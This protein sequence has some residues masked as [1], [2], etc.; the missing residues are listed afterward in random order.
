V[1]LWVQNELS[2]FVTCQNRGCILVMFG[3]IDLE[4]LYSIKPIM[5]FTFILTC[6]YLRWQGNLFLA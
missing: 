2:S 6:H 5:F 3:K 4:V 1:S